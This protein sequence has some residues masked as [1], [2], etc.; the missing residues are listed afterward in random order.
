MFLVEMPEA[1]L[2]QAAAAICGEVTAR[3]A[4]AIALAEKSAP[5]LRRVSVSEMVAKAAE[6]GGARSDAW[7]HAR[8]CM[9]YLLAAKSAEAMCAAL[10]DVE[11]LETRAELEEFFVLQARALGM[12]VEDLDREK[13]IAP[14]IQ[15]V[16]RWI[17]EQLDS[18]AAVRATALRPGANDVSARLSDYATSTWAWLARIFARTSPCLWQGRNRWLG[19]AA[20]PET[21]SIQTT[22]TSIGVDAGAA[23]SD[24]AALTRFMAESQANTRRQLASKSVQSLRRLLVSTG[25]LAPALALPNWEAALPKEGGG[26]LASGAV[27]HEQ[28][29]ALTRVVREAQAARELPYESGDEWAE[30]VVA[31][32][33][34]AKAAGAHLVE[35]DD[36]IYGAYRW[37][38]IDD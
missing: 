18:A 4:F 37:P 28:L 30:I 27:R 35:A 12:S 33:T 17:L 21:F 2:Q 5:H 10:R 15:T 25:E 16:Q 32:A 24:S 1:A 11:K 19:G 38:P 3:Q 13:F 29:D 22:V 23:S 9:P 6:R 31:A 14:E 34:H 26:N 8:N 7:G 20:F 36:A